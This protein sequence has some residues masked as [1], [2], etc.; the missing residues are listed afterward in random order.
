MSHHAIR[1][2]VPW[3]CLA[4][5]AAC[6]AP[7]AMPPSSAPAPQ[8][9][10]ISLLPGSRLPPP[11]EELESYILVRD[12][13][14]VTAATVNLATATLVSRSAAL[15]GRARTAYAAA[16]IIRSE[17]GGPMGFT[18]WSPQRER[19]NA[20]CE[21]ALRD[22]D[23]I[24]AAHPRS[25]EAPEAMFTVGQ[26]SDYPNLN[27]FDWALDAYRLTIQSYP[28]TPWA[29]EAGERIRVI[30]GMFE[31]G[32]DSPHMERATKPEPAH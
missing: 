1:L 3:L 23:E 21:L 22:L 2:S 5:V 28:G 13:P 26:I 9:A 8:A 32:K 6:A 4:V 31:A 30:E 25:P 17:K 14:A 20:Y 19:F 27:E 29:Q 7:Q 15:L 24:V 18:G 10:A 16:L 12:D 11:A